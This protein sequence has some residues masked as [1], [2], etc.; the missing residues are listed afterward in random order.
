[1]VYDA[2]DARKEA[3]RELADGED[4]A[5]AKR[6]AKAATFSAAANAFDVLAE[7]LAILRAVESRGRLGITRRIR[8]TIGEVFR[9]AAAT[10]PGRPN[11]CTQGRDRCA[12]RPT[13]RSHH[14]AQGLRLTAPCNRRF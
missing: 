11:E 12:D 1:M 2:S 5:V 13:P 6:L 9:F 8:A 10:G 7:I 4:P 3:K 14:R